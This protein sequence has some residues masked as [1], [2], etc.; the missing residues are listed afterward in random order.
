MVR[1]MKNVDSILQSYD[2]IFSSDR[3]IFA[4]IMLCRE[5]ECPGSALVLV[6][7]AIDNLAFLTMDEKRGDVTGADFRRVAKQYIGSSVGA[8]ADELW[9][10]RCGILH[11][12]TADSKLSRERH[13]LKL[14][15]QYGSVQPKRSKREGWLMVN[16]D[17]LIIRL[18]KAIIAIRKQI[19]QG[20]LDPLV[21]S[22]RLSQMFN[23]EHSKQLYEYQIG[24]SS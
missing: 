5:H 20:K 16:L 6:Y 21:T 17:K 2:G 14:V 1:I 8:T 10:A 3:G 22:K 18:R 4:G 24:K 7:S 9:A 23:P 12:H 11:C 19:E 13:I 15:Y